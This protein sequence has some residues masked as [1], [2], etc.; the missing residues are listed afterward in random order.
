[1]GKKQREFPFLYFYYYCIPP[2]SSFC[3]RC[4]RFSMLW[5]N[6]AFSTFFSLS[7]FTAR[8]FGNVEFIWKEGTALEFFR[9]LKASPRGSKYRT[10][11]FML[12]YCQYLL[13]LFALPL[14]LLFINKNFISAPSWHTALKVGR[15]IF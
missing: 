10:W 5:K 2:L 4:A 1:M 11:K 15:C 9:H 12:F 7:L 3:T 8:I 6:Y 14:W 13:F